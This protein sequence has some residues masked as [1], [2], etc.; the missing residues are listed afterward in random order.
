MRRKQERERRVK[1]ADKLSFPP[2]TPPTDPDPCAGGK[3]EETK[4][5]TGPALLPRVLC[6]FHLSGQVAYDVAAGLVELLLLL[7]DVQVLLGGRGNRLH[8]LTPQ[9]K[10]RKKKKKKKKNRFTHVYTYTRICKATE[11]QTAK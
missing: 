11:Q 9:N 2:S 10:N 6:C 3:K 1:E 8:H 7:L 5:S 4:A